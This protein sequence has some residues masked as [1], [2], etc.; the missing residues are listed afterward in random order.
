MTHHHYS[1]SQNSIIS[2]DYSWFLTKNLFNFVYFPWKLHN[3]YCD[4]ARFPH[5]GE[6]ILNSLHNKSLADC[7]EVSQTWQEFIGNERFYKNR[8]EDEMRFQKMCRI[9]PPHARGKLT[10]TNILQQ[11][12]EYLHPIEQ[13]EITII[14]D[15][16]LFHLQVPKC[17]VPVQKL[18]CQR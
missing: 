6:Q 16:C 14:I 9:L 3:R 11:I 13:N 4:I 18:F 10:K 2:F 1:N 7:R 15:L 8:I 12:A 5:L 17:F